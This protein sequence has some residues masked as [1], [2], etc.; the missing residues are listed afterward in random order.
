LAALAVESGLE[1]TC[2]H[3]PQGRARDVEVEQGGAPAVLAHHDELART[4][5]DQPRGR[6][7]DHRRDHGRHRL[8][9]RAELDPGAYGTGVQVSDAHMDALPLDRHDW[10]GDWNYTLRPREHGD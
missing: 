2:C 3:F 1:I 7:T 6:R 4:A 10:H 9:V 8:R 5:P